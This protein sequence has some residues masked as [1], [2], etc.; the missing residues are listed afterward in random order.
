[1]STSTIRIGYSVNQD[2]VEQHLERAGLTVIWIKGKPSEKYPEGKPLNVGYIPEIDATVVKLRSAQIP[3]R[4]SSG[5]LDI[6]FV[7]TDCVLD[8]IDM[9][10]LETRGTSYAYGRT[11]DAPQS[12][13]EFTTSAESEIPD[14]EHIPEGTVMITERPHLTERIANDYGYTTE[15]YWNQGNTNKFKQDLKKAGKIGIRVIDGAGPQQ[16]YENPLANDEILALVT[17][18]GQT[19]LDYELRHLMK[20][21]DI[22][23][24]PLLNTESLKD[25]EKAKTIM[26]VLDKLDEVAV[27]PTEGRIQ[28]HQIEAQ[29]SPGNTER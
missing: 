28:F 13:L 8:H 24:I 3:E 11:L 20:V 2:S 7:G 16:L 21:V 15:R 29:S 23:T 6:G 4:V 19:N 17:E 10:N 5:H 25:Q 27:Y 22:E 12:Y 18:T 14:M 9:E 26:F 1:M